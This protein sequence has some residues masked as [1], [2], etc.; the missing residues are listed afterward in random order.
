MKICLSIF[1]SDLFWVLCGIEY[2]FWVVFLLPMMAAKRPP[3]MDTIKKLN[4]KDTT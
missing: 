4:Q 1:S 2:F 3:K